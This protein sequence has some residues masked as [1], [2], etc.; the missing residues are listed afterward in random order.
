[1]SFKDVSQYFSLTDISGAVNKWHWDFGD[2]TFSNTQN[3]TH[4]YA[5][6]GTYTVKLTATNTLGQDAN[7]VKTDFI[8]VGVTPAL[9]AEFSA[10][11][12]YA[13]DRTVVNFR[14]QSTGTYTSCIW[15]FG[16]GTTSTEIAPMHVYNVPGAYNISLTVT[17]PS[18]SDTHT[19]PAFIQN[20]IGLIFTDNTF[21]EK[22]HFYSRS[23]PITFGKVIC[24]TKFS[25]IPESDLKYAR[26]FY[27]TCNSANYFVGE[28]R[29]GILFCTV[30]DLAYYTGV[31][32]LRD[33]L[34]GR[35]DQEILAHLNSIQPIHEYINF[36]L[37]PPSM[38][39]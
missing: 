1:V 22:P 26:M 2:G 11:N 32:Y 30:G 13:P 16:D 19:E 7:C 29:R 35:T 25:K 12:R 24:N 34:N 21:H 23:G 15:D 9:H 20:I 10:D 37:K 28:F 18:G 31:D 27:G 39:K 14:N 5:S 3:P 17:G 33:Y 38:R 4:I 36:N 8:N 6:P